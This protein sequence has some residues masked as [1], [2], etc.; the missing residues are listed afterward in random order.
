MRVEAGQTRF[1]DGLQGLQV[2][3]LSTLTGDYVILRKDALPA[4]HLAVVLD[5]ADYGIT[6]IVRGTDLLQATA[7][8]I[9]LQRALQLPTPDYL[10]VPIVV[11]DAGQKLSK[12]TGADAVEAAAAP[13][14]ATEILSYLGLSAP[15]ALVGAPPRELWSWAIENWEPALL[16]GRTRL[17]R[18]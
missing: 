16:A 5:D 2:H 3:E 18:G 13:A 8:H 15:A 17:A 1:V 9:H 10:H 7:V 4:Y 6:H 14:M 12:Q 11:N